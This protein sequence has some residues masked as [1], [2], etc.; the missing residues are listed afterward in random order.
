MTT[1]LNGLVGGL[2]VGLGAGIV[3]Q[4]LTGDLTPRAM[5]PGVFGGREATTRWVAGAMQVAYGGLAGLALIA[6]EL[7]VLGLLAV[8]PT[9]AE[10][11]GIALA[12]SGLL[13]GMLVVGW[14]AVSPA[15]DR[16]RLRGLIVYHVGYGLGLGV[17]IRMTWIT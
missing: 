10:A 8:P 2:L 15:L 6:L 3:A 9:I 4:V 1:L 14:R 7:F 11:L 17:W 16:P 13:L 5:P 12:W